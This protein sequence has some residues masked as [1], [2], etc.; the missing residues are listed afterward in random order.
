[1]NLEKLTA[2]RTEIA[3]KQKAILEETRGLFSGGCKD[4]F[5]A[6]PGLVSFS[7]T[8]YTPGFNDGDPC[9]FST[10]TDYPAVLFKIGDENVEF[11][12]NSGEGDPDEYPEHKEAI[13][14]A[15]TAV[16]EFLGIFGDSEYEA[17]F[18]DNVKVTVT[19]DGKATINEYDC[20]Y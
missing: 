15:Q 10:N 17:I 2:L 8:Q 1:M 20:G 5:I 14:A 16:S 7:W 3:E 18:G 9:E 4:I 12:E 19:A 6:N 13:V 11:D